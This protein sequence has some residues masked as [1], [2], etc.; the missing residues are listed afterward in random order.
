MTEDEKYY[1]SNSVSAKAFDVIYALGYDL[2]NAEV[3]KFN[4]R[5]FNKA[6]LK[7]AINELQGLLEVLGKQ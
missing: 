3:D 1:F 6:Q 7:K 2:M 5:K 4:Q